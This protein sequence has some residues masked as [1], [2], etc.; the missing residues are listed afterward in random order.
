MKDISTREDI[1]TLVS[2][3]YEKV[4]KDDV[5]GYIFTEVAHLEWDHHMPIMYDFWETLLLDAQ[6]YKGNPMVKHIQLDK[7]EPLKSI[8]FD[9]WLALWRQTVGENFEGKKADEAIVR[10]ENIARLMEFKVHQRDK[11]D[12]NN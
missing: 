2:K 5:I 10:A 3:F 9:R 6:K 4:L 1:E 7:Q 12:T 8:H 11:Y